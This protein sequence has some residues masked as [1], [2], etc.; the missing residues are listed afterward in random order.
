MNAECRMAGQSRPKPGA[1]QVQ[2][3][4]MRGTSRGIATVSQWAWV[5]Q[6]AWNRVHLLALQTLVHLPGALFSPAGDKNRPC[7]ACGLFGQML[8][9]YRWSAAHAKRAAQQPAAPNPPPTKR[10]ATEII[11]EE[12]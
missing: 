1:S 7:T 12:R 9:A 8:L 10:T 6:N 3:R 5:G 2:A 4:Y 11:H